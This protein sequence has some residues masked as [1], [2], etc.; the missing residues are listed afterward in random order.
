MGASLPPWDFI[1]IILALAT[2]VPWRAA[3]RVRRLLRE[4]QMTTGDRLALYAST[5]AFQWFAAVVVGWRALAR[6]LN[7]AELGLTIQSPLR[8]YG[9]AA[10]LSLIL[11]ANQFFAL[12]RLSRH[13]PTRTSRLIEITRKLMPQASVEVLAFIALSATVG[14]CEEFLYRGFIYAVIDAALGGAWPVA[15]L[16]SA[17][18]FSIAHLYQGRR[19]M[20]ATFFAGI[21]FATARFWTGSLVPCVVAHAIADITAGVA[22]RRYLPPLE[23]SASTPGAGGTGAEAE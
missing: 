14:V 7:L 13:P 18:L 1:A 20:L 21:V 22:A 16:G 6:G 10:G 4:P 3:A 17:A 2:L 8:S 5:I 19:G 11:F 9:I 23:A 15:I 12:K